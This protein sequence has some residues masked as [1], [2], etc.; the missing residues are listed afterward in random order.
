MKVLSIIENISESHGGPTSVL[1]NQ[2]EV[3]NKKK[4]IIDILTLKSISFFF[5][6]K[7]LLFS[8]RR[9]RIY[10]FFNKYDL[11]HFH[12]IW[13]IKNFFLVYFIN[14]LLIK[15]FFVGHGYLDTW[16]IRNKYLKK[17]TFITLFLQRAYNS[18]F[19][20]FYSTYDEYLESLKNVKSHNV[21]IIPNGISLDKYPK[22]ELTKKTKK[23]NFIFWKNTS[24]KRIR[25]DD[26]N[27]KKFTRRFF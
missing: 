7:C 3:I 23:K 22:R 21:F 8:S 11:I 24:K 9:V 6:V 17:K 18:A 4:K 20:S 19:A 5:L 27:Y 15:F 1:L 14:K 26:K 10:N 13:S 16:S 12:Q 2:I 25:F